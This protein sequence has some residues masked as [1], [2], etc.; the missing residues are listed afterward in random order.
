MEQQKRFLLAMVVSA[1]IVLGWQY[2]FPPPAPTD[3]GAG[4]EQVTEQGD[5]GEKK[6]D[7]DKAPDQAKPVADAAPKEQPPAAKPRKNVAV[8]A[9][10]LVTSDFKVTLTNKGGRVIGIDLLDP[11]QY[12]KAGN[13]L[14]SYPEGSEN[15]PFELSFDKGAIQLPAELVYEVAEKTDK[16][17]VY[18]FVD[19]NGAY[20]V[21]KIF[22]VGDKNRY[23]LG[24]DVVITNISKTASI[25]ERLTM[26]LTGHSD[27]NVEKSMLDFRPD[28]LEGI[29]HVNA[30]TERT[31]ISGLDEPTN[32]TGDTS[33]GAIGTRYFIWTVL[34]SKNAEKCNISKDGDFVKTQL[35]WSDFSIQPGSSYTYDSTLYMGPKDLDVLNELGSE[36]G[37]SVDYGILSILALPMRWL[38]NLFFSLVGNWGIAIIL[39]TLLI[40][41]VTWPFTEKSYAN[42]ERMKEIQPKLDELRTKYENDQQRLAEETMKL[43]KEQKF[44]P[45]GGC[46]PMVLQMPILYALY[47]MII[48]SVELYQAEFALWYTDLSASDPYFVLPIL[49]G[50]MMLVQQRFMTPP[51]SGNNPTAQQTQAMMKIMPIIFTGVMLFL[52]SG[53][54]LYYSLNLLLGILQQYLI[55]RKFARRRQAAA[56]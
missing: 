40:K 3:A 46:L 45:L 53:L 8:E 37:E 21:D 25:N 19:P 10:E 11:A 50:V 24:L 47:V 34:P 49:M 22:S 55:K 42:T 4:T 48:N 16:K 39:L 23:T 30:D 15:F 51:S 14:A 1:G 2:F 35:V 27:P 6:G 31:L 9:A 36:L 56:V 38:L 5:K 18:R 29:C 52:P 26:T 54:V 44:N 17:I 7:A 20:Q 41:I 12:Q 32:F 28:E 43:F 13:L 33:W